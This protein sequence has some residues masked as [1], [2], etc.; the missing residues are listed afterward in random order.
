MHVDSS[1]C[2]GIGSRRFRCELGW[3]RTRG[4]CV[5]G[6]PVTA[7]SAGADSFASSAGAELVVTLVLSGSS[8][9]MTN[10]DKRM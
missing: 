4:D 3:R 8:I 6:G 7:E 2:S 9:G 10:A 1:S 5:G